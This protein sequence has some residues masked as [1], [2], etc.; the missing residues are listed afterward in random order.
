MRLVDSLR[1]LMTSIVDYAGLF[2]P[3]SLDMATTVAN[4]RRYAAGDH[5]WMLGR[6]IIPA[7]RLDEFEK[8]LD[9]TG[10]PGETEDTWRISALIGENIDGDIDRIF[11]FNQRHAPGDSEPPESGGENPHLH[12]APSTMG[13][14]VIDA[15]ELK[16]PGSSFI[17]SAM[18]IIPEQLEPY[19]EVPGGSADVRGMIA[20]MA[21]TGARAKIRTGGVTPDAFPASR[22][23]S[24][25]IKACSAADVPF[26]AT[27]GLHHPVRGEFPLTYEAGCARGTM[28]GFVNVFVAAAAVRAVQAPESDVLAVLEESNPKAFVFTNSGVTWRDKPIDLARLARVRETFAVSFGSCSFEEPIADLKSLGWI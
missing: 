26:K 28:Y 18:K 8:L 17:D 20:A 5:A 6:L 15:I 1:I 23:V 25:F 19:F 2:P 24:V 7:V 4:W 21:G 10:T 13:G 16:A 12:H 9:Q 3:A 22:Q 27:A 11:E 14:V